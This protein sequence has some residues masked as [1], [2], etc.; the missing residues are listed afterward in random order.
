MTRKEYG[1]VWRSADGRAWVTFFPHTYRCHDHYQGY[2]I[3]PVKS[4]RRVGEE[5][6]GFPTME[7]AISE[8]L[9]ACGVQS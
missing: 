2:V 6:I 5:A 8:T 3:D 9:K 1:E 7:K 4:N